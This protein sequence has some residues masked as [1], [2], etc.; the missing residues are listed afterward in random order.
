MTLWTRPALD[1]SSALCYVY[2]D[3]GTP[4]LKELEA[5]DMT[6]KRAGSH[7]S[8]RPQAHKWLRAILTLAILSALLVAPLSVWAEEGGNY[9]VQPGDT[10]W[11]ISVSHNTTVEAITAAN[12]ISDAGLIRVGQRLVIPGE[13]FDPTAAA[14]ALKPAPARPAT[15]AARGPRVQHRPVKGVYMTLFSIGSQDYRDHIFDLIQNTELNAVI[16]DIKGDRGYVAYPSQ[17]PM[18][19]EIG[20]QEF[21]TMQDIGDLMDYFKAK[22]IY[23]IARIVTFKDDPLARARPDLAVRNSRTGGLWIDDEGLAWADPFKEEVWDY[24]VAIAREAARLGFDEVQF[25]Y[26][27]FPTDGAVS[28]AVFSRPVTEETRE[29][30][31]LGFL[32]RARQALSP[33]GVKLAV[34]TFGYTAWRDDDMGIGQKLEA[35][36]SVVDV[37]SPMVYPST[38]SDGIPGYSYAVAH[39]YEI[40]YQSINAAL[41]RVDQTGVEIRPWL[42]DFPD[43]AFDLRPYRATEVQAQIK[44]ARDAGASGWMLWDPRV[45]YTRAALGPD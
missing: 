1:P 38:F 44:A 2:E 30:A 27:R 34:D 13:D 20:A 12:G 42:Q 40:V 17:V 18:A 3:F 5:C 29:Q 43:Y 35:L 22:S 6:R 28:A 15:P 4:I 32:T 16:I 26:I 9:V 8:G 24:N 11:D 45:K 33:L 23:S 7:Y 31:I 36:A 14:P 25:D 10:L 39:P 21:I 41:D 19:S 37:I